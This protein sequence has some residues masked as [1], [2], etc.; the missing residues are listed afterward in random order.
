VAEGHRVF[1]IGAD[2]IGLGGYV[3]Q[4]LE[5]VQGEIAALPPKS[6]AA[7]LPYG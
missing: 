1:N 7:R 3:K 5:L 2:V 6:A 4:R